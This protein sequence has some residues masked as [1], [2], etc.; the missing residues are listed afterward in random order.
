MNLEK[1]VHREGRQG[2][3]GKQSTSL[4]I[5]ITNLV[6]ASGFILLLISL[7]SLASLAVQMLD[8]G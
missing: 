3:E 5:K 8:L 2:R 4:V 6:I 1:A 7:A